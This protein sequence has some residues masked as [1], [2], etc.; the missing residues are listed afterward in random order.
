MDARMPTSSDPATIEMLATVSVAA[1][2]AVIILSLVL[3]RAVRERDRLKQ[4]GDRLKQRTDRTIAEQQAEIDSLARFRDI[5]DAA[6]TADQLRQAS[7]ALYEGAKRKEQEILDAAERAA[8]EITIKAEQ[9]AAG[10]LE[11]AQQ[12]AAAVRKDANLDAKSRRER[13]ESVLAEASAQAER[14]IA[15]A[16]RRAEQI[17]GDAYRALQ[18]ADRLG[19][20]AE[21]M[22]NVIEGYGDRYLKP[23]FGLLDELAET[24]GFDDSGRQLK[25]ARERTRLMVAEQR[26]ATCDYVEAKRRDTAEQFVVDAFNGKVDTILSRVKTTNYGV[27]EQEIRDAFALVNQ[28]GKAFRDARITREYLQ[29]RLDELRWATA[30][31][32]KRQ[33]EKAE[34]RRIR[35]QIR[36]EQKAR[37]EIERALKESAREEE[38]LQKALAKVQ[39]EA[40]QASEAQR[41][42][43]DAR[44]AELH[45]RLA[46][47]EARNQRALSMAQQTKA[48]HVYVISNIGSFGEDVFK[49]GMTRRLEPLDRVRELG[50]ASVPFAFDVHALIW[51]EDAP[52][53]ETALHRQFIQAQ[54][55]KVNPRKEFFQVPLGAIRRQLEA[56]GIQAAWTMTAA[57]AEYRESLALA[58][59]LTEAPETAREWMQR[60]YE[61]DLAADR[62]EMEAE[63][64]ALANA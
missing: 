22:R 6:A 42:L 48:G 2:I 18:E 60:Q 27:L 24:Y 47:A 13:A 7:K 33:E 25:A 10:V 20:V 29:S 58:K 43:F 11:T 41:A 30:V 15:S 63:E 8:R 36:E 26:A 12:E 62:E 51:S 50:D 37:R 9:E 3:A 14:I 52:A 56:K 1:L 16:D 40:A 28:N 54:V 34:Q 19:E 32:V 17:A 49:V 21:A 61:Y 4:S 5:R 64:E 55:N 35:E 31:E 23:T 57:A 45:A 38:S 44:L 46:E 59:Q 39:A 53:L